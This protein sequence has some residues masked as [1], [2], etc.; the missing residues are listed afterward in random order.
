MPPHTF[1]TSSVSKLQSS[2]TPWYARMGTELGYPTCAWLIAFRPVTAQHSI[3]IAVDRLHL[4][5]RAHCRGCPNSLYV[6]DQ[7]LQCSVP[8]GVAAARC[9]CSRSCHAR[10]H[11][12]YPFVAAKGS[13]I[14]QAACCVGRSQLCTDTV[15]ICIH[16]LSCGRI[17]SA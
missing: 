2:G 13:F 16:C 7:H 11:R 9:S 12:L 17:S 1:G 10:D 3:A 14:H 8:S 4:V 15:R 5:S 6:S